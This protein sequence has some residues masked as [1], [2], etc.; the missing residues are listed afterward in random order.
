MSIRLNEMEC[1][2]IGVLL[3]KSVTT[4]EQY[5]LSINA[6]VNGCNQKSNRAPVLS[7]SEEEVKQTLESLKAKRLVQLSSGYGSRV[8]KVSQRFCNTE[9]GE[10]KLTDQQMAIVAELLLRGAQTPG[11][12][13]GR[14]QRMAAFSDMADVETT[15]ASLQGF[16][17]DALVRQLAR[18]PGKRE[19]RYQHCF[20]E[21]APESEPTPLTRE[22]SPPLTQRVAELEA[23]LQCV[24]LRLDELERKAG[25]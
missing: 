3:E 25:S 24:L 12:L 10:L 2:I 4:P 18:E 11:E 21:A 7:L 1:R 6:L 9:F 16:Q 8:D 15:L 22:D 17:P 13:R 23:A 5:P 19:V 14:C 20:N